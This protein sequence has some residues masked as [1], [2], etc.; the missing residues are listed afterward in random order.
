MFTQHVPRPTMATATATIAAISIG[1]RCLPIAD[2]FHRLNIIT[3]DWPDRD[4]DCALSLQ[5][6]AAGSLVR[7]PLPPAT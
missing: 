3:P 5:I 6:C 7:C 2:R 4:Q 1:R